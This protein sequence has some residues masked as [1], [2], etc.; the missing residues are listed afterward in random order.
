MKIGRMF[1]FAALLQL[2]GSALAQIG[3]PPGYFPIVQG[4]TNQTVTTCVPEGDAGFG[5]Y[6]GDA[7]DAPAAPAE[8]WADRWG[9]IAVASDNPVVGIAIDATSKRDAQKGAI[10]DCQRRGGAECKVEI[11]YTNQCGVLVVSG[12]QY[13]A[14]RAATIQEATEIGMQI[15]QQGNS[16]SCRVY[17]SGCSLPVR[18][19]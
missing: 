15:C 14:A 5:D 6:D 8:R 13:N 19:Q 12:D 1:V 4:P 17:Y 11:A 9:A 16:E 18:I 2:S 3:C 10:D 7:S